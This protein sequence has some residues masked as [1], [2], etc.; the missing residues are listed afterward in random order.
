MRHEIRL[1]DQNLPGFARELARGCWTT[2]DTRMTEPPGM[3]LYRRLYGGIREVL[4]KHVMAFRYCGGAMSC[5]DSLFPRNGAAHVA[6]EKFPGERVRIYLTD[7]DTPP[8]T[9]MNE[10]LWK[11]LLATVARYPG[12]RLPGM[13]TAL[14]RQI[15]KVFRGRMYRSERCGVS[16]LCHMNEAYD[17]WDRRDPLNAVGAGARPSSA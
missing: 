6:H 15:E 9:V 17:P 1:L 16:P 11:A 2:V 13:A 3:F 5:E 7:G 8:E 12:R 14:R 10:I 4:R